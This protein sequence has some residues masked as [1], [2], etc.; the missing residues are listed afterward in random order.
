MISF[1]V[2]SQNAILL[3]TDLALDL[4]VKE[5]VQKPVHIYGLMELPGKVSSTDC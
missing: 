5:R 3:D 1:I 4:I 2:H